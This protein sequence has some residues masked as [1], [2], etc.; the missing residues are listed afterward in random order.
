MFRALIR[1]EADVVRVTQDLEERRPADRAGWTL[2]CRDRR[3]SP[4]GSVGQ[5][6]DD[7]VVAGCVLGERPPNERRSLFVDLNRA[8]LTPL[9]I[10]R[11]DVEVPE[12]SPAAVAAARAAG[13]AS[14]V[15]HMGAHALGA[16][17]GATTPMRGAMGPRLF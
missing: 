10:L 4:S 15:A 5:Q 16:A 8:V 11:A 2:R 3:E 14:G 12:G 17:A 7:R 1:D 6:F 9:L 13:Q